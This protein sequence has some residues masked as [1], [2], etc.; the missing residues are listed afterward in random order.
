M[1]IADTERHMQAS[2]SALKQHSTNRVKATDVVE[3]ELI[4]ISDVVLPNSELAPIRNS[5]NV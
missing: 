5:K 2:E 4:Y 3:I 1:C